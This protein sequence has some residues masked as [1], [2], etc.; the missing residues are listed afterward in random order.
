M[1]VHAHVLPYETAHDD[2]ERQRHAQ[3]HHHDRGVKF[4]SAQ[5][6]QVT[7]HFVALSVGLSTK[8]AIFM[9][10]CVFLS[11]LSMKMAVFMDGNNEGV[12]I[13]SSV[14]QQG[15]FGLRGGSARGL[16]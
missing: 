13:L 10:K 6:S 4:V 5:E 7:F 11:V 1:T 15:W 2:H 14:P 9:D 12:P 3:S 8:T 16:L